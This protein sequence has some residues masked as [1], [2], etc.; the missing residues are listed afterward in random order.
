[1]KKIS[2]LLSTILLSFS[3]MSCSLDEPIPPTTPTEEPHISID[4][5]APESQSEVESELVLEGET[6]PQS[7][8]ELQ[9]QPEDESEVVPH[10]PD[11]TFSS[12]NHL[13]GETVTEEIF[14]DYKVT[15]LNF[16]EPWCG[17]CVGEMPDLESIY[18]EYGSGTGD[19]NIIGCFSTLD[20]AKEAVRQCGVTYPSIDY[21]SAFDVF[22]TGYVPATIF[23]D[24]NGQILSSEYAD[25]AGTIFVGSRDYDTW[26]TI[27]EEMLSSCE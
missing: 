7:V 15:M 23:F 21:T 6:E 10:N 12:F 14:Y 18:E 9:P 2:L 25:E 19:V 16:W 24:E 22:Q 5:S 11:I 4:E 26:K 1:M 13:N 27:I 3:L 20:G 8:S 17:P